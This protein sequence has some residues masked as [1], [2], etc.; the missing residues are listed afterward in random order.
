MTETTADPIAGLDIRDQARV[1]DAVEVLQAD[2]D[3]RYRDLPY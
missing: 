2:M 3:M 1:A